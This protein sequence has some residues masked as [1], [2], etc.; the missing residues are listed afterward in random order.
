[1]TKTFNWKV[2]FSKD[3]I[4]FVMRFIGALLLP[5]F[6]YLGIEWQSL[7]SWSLV[8]DALI[9]IVSNPVAIV[10]MILNAL[11]MSV[12]PSTKGI[13]DSTRVMNYSKPN[14]NTKQ[15]GGQ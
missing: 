14:K 13:S 10:L 2:R 3:N 12:D 5:A 6:I 1:M 15:K 7:T 11:N 9:Q 4:S 8:W